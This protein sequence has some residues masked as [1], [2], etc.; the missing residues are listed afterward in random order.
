[1]NK[2]TI[3]RIATIAVAAFLVGMFFYQVAYGKEIGKKGI[4]AT[5]SGPIG[6][7][8]TV[9]IT[10]PNGYWATFRGPP[11]TILHNFTMISEPNK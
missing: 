8:G 5:Y 10:A 9:T 4:W 7:N 11:G 1:M 6:K 2:K 3:E